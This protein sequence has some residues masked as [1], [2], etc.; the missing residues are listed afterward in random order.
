MFFMFHVSSWWAQKSYAI[1]LKP[2][3][4]CGKIKLF[5]LRLLLSLDHRR[6]SARKESLLQRPQKLDSFGVTW[7]VE[8]RKAQILLSQLWD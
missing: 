2:A 3:I 5:L 8:G 4:S 6:T 7:D 1:A